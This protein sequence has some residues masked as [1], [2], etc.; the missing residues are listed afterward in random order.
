MSDQAK[1]IET[2]SKRELEVAA[3]DTDGSSYKEIDGLGAVAQTYRR[4]KL[5]FA[6][7]ALKAKLQPNLFGRKLLEAIRGR[8]QFQKS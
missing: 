1:V 2:L 5:D 6:V 8:E 7:E 3:A 4:R